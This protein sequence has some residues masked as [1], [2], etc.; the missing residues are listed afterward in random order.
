M[1]TAII[2]N[3]YYANGALKSNDKSKGSTIAHREGTVMYGVLTRAC[4]KK[5]FDGGT[6]A[7]PEA[8][9]RA[10]FAR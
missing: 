3:T 2:E 7:N 8:G 1:A 4:G 10:Y 5:P 9:V 6:V